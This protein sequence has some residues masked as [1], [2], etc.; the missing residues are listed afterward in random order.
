MPID[1]NSEDKQITDANYILNEFNK[2][3]S[4]IENKISKVLFRAVNENNI[5]KYINKC[6]FNK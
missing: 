2:Y 1:N 6:K 4:Q 3:F 5:I